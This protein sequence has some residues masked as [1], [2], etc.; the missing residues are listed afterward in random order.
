M[1]PTRIVS[2]VSTGA[3]ACIAAWSSWT[4]MVHVALKFGE[5]PEVAYVLP[6]SVDGMLLVASTAIVNDRRAH[7]PV[8][9]SARTALLTGVGASIAANIAAAQPTLGARIVAAWPAVALLLVVEMLSRTRRI[10]TASTNNSKYSI[11]ANRP[12][13]AGHLDTTP[14]TGP[15]TK[16]TPTARTPTEP[17]HPKAPGHR[18]PRRGRT[19]EAIANIRAERPEA[20]VTDIANQLGVTE[21]HVRR[22]LTAAPTD[23]VG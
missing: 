5:R 1:D 11:D 18:A 17:S 4:H 15:P 22:L 10:P 16:K 3:V 19:S 12:S 7:R 21:R 13:R 6:I 2:N 23:N 20:T 9:W 14:A 8:R